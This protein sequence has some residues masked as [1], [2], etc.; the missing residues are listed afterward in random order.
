MYPLYLLTVLGVFLVFTAYAVLK[1]VNLE[2]DRKIDT[3]SQHYHRLLK[4]KTEYLILKE[5]VKRL[6]LKPVS[7]KE[8]VEL[9]LET[10]D[11]LVKMYDGKIVKDLVRNGKTYSITIGFD[12]YPES[13][14]DLYDFIKELTT[15]FRPIVLVRQFKLIQTAYGS[16][17]YFEVE[18]AQPFIG[19]GNGK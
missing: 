13:G 2:L 10:A 8:A 7:K 5:D 1:E 6:N 18:I 4:K 11:R 9:V 14:A 15:P 19:N 12:Y 17:V 16:K 3:L